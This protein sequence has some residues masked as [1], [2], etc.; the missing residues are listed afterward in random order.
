[1]DPTATLPDVLRLAR[2]RD[3]GGE[4]LR[5]IGGHRRW[6][7][8]LLV[9]EAL[10]RN[11]TT[12]L[13]VALRFVSELTWKGLVGVLSCAL[14]HP[15]VRRRAMDRL[16]LKLRELTS[17]ERTSLAR[18]A[19]ADVGALLLGVCA[20]DRELGAVL[21]NGRLRETDLLAA[22]G[23]SL[24]PEAL[25]QVAAHPRW[26]DRY[27]VVRALAMCD[28][29]PADLAIPLLDHLHVQDLREAAAFSRLSEALRA[30]ARRLLSER[31]QNPYHP[32]TGTSSS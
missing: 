8:D 17:G 31:T 3:A 5:A 23:Q 29:A 32:R 24:A 25:R 21:D 19:P 10:V 7:R 28:R 6:G 18:E 14:I 30:E 15:Q 2:S 9:R 26:R 13:D 27:V 22:I 11:P 4:L 16:K 12:P 20:P 1:M